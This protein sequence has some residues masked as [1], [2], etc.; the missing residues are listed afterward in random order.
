MIEVQ[1]LNV[2]HIFYGFAKKSLASEVK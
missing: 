1:V 2:R